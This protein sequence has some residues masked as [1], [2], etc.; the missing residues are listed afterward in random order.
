MYIHLDVFLVLLTIFKFNNKS[1]VFIHGKKHQE[2]L[3]STL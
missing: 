3:N 1:I 2:L